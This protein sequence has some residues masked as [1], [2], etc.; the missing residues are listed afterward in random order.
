MTPIQRL[1]RCA[2]RVLRLPAHKSADTQNQKRRAQAQLRSTLSPHLRKDVGV[3][4][5]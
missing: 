4:D 1:A 5:G 3:E 2:K